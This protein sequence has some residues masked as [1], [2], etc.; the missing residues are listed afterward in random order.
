MPT[1]SPGRVTTSV[2]VST[3]ALGNGVPDLQ[4][5][6]D[7]SSNPFLKFAPPGDFYSPIPTGRKWLAIELRCLIAA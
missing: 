4:H 3:R 6:D 1:I 5:Q 7:A 2:E